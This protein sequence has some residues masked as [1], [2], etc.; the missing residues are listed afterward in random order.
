MEQDLAGAEALEIQR[1]T[2]Q[3]TLEG[4]FGT[5]HAITCF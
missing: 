2:M 3:K 1:G 4:L 5:R